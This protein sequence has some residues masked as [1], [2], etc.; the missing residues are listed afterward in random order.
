MFNL[1]KAEVLEMEM[2]TPGGFSEMIQR[3]ISTQN[4]PELIKIFKELILK[5]YGE[6][7]ADGKRFVKSPELSEAFSQTEAFSNLFMEL[8]IN[9]DEAAA[10]VNGI[11]PSDFAKQA[12]KAMTDGFSVSK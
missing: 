12:K 2:A 8:A 9:A 1:S 10:F 6:K 4:T 3:V 7:S 11:M 5:S